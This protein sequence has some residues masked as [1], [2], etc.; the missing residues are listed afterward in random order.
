MGAACC[1]LK[2]QQKRKKKKNL[3]TPF[4][5]KKKNY[6]KTD[7]HQIFVPFEFNKI[8]KLWTKVRKANNG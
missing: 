1:D 5:R 7:A 8:S 4:L 2:K 3:W 6:L